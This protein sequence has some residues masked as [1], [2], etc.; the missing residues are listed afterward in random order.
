MSTLDNLTEEIKKAMLEKDTIKL[1]SLR[2]I[3]SA[4][5]IAETSI[6][7][8]D[9][10]SNDEKVKILQKLVKQRK[11]SAI[12]YQKQGRTDLA[13]P[14]LA[15]AKVISCFLPKQLSYNQVEIIVSEIISELSAK[16]LKD[17]GRV[18]GVSNKRIAGR[19]EGKVVA[20]IVKQKLSS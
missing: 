7:F 12:I 11:D 19:A 5:L 1:E 17:M 3:K 8:V 10:L 6:G 20:S 9:E 18:M 4:F 16:G 14:E 13:E 15:Q 2:A